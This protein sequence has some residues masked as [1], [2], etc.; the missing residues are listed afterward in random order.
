METNVNE[1]L[2]KCRNLSTPGPNGGKIEGLYGDGWRG[3]D[4]GR[5]CEGPSRGRGA[6]VSGRF[7]MTV[8][9]I[10]DGHFA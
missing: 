10:V 3:M 4:T 5:A 6:K 8:Y 7:G 2:T 1:P 9:G